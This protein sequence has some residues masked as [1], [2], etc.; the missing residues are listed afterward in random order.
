MK[1]TYWFAIVDKSYKVQNVIADTYYLINSRE[2][3]IQAQE[4]LRRDLLGDFRAIINFQKL[5]SV[6]EKKCETVKDVQK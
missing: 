6:K 1:Y 5:G 4:D 2:R 3:M